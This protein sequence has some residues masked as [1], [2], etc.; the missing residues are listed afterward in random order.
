MPVRRARLPPRR[1]VRFASIFVADRR[2]YH[3]TLSTIEIGAEADAHAA[4]LTGTD[5]RFFP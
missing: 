2:N 1:T 4:E 3:A 5:V